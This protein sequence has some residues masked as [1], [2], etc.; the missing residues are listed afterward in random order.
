MKSKTF[1]KH[2]YTFML[3]GLMAV[4]LLFFTALKG[5]MMWKGDVWLGIA[6]QFPEYG[7]VTLARAG[8][9]AVGKG[10]SYLVAP[11]PK[12]YAALPKKG[13]VWLVYVPNLEQPYAIVVT[14]R[15]RT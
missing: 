15:D 3:L 14:R 11:N 12:E 8:S 10:K 13:P 6:M 9:Y 1:E 5:G 2:S 7:V 4:V